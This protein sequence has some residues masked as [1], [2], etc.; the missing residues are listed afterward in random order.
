MGE[1]ARRAV[2]PVGDQFYVTHCTTTDSVLNNPGYTVRAASSDD[3]DALDAAFRYPPYELPIDMWRDLPAVEEAPRRLARTAPK[4][5]GPVWAVHS[6]Y[7]AKDTVD[8]DRSYFSH[9]LLLDSA[10]PAAVLESWGA[11]GWATC[12][13]QGET[14][15]LDRRGL[16]VGTLVGE[17]ALTAFLG[18]RPPG[19]TELSRTVCPPRLR[20]SAAGRRDL[21]AR[22]LHALL[23]LDEEKGKEEGRRRL[24]V[25]A[26]PGVV[27]LLLYGAVR[28]LPRA[29]TDDL[30]FTTYE[31]YHRNLRDYKAARVVGT[32]LGPPENGKGLD[33]DLGTTR[34]LALDTIVPARS[35][36]ELRA[37]LP[38]G[39][40]ELIGLA[41]HGHWALLPAVRDDIGRDAP[42]LPQAGAAIARAAGLARVRAGKA[43][44]DLLLELQTD[45]QAAM[46]LKALSDEVW[47]VVEAAALGPRRAEVCAAFREALAEPKHV[48]N[49]WKA[50]VTA[51]VEDDFGAWDARWAVIR[52]TAGRADA[53][54]LL[55]GLVGSER[56]EDRLLKQPTKVRNKMR[57]ACGDVDLIPPRPLLVPAGLGELGPLLAGPPNWAGYT[58]FVLMA[59]DERD[60]LAHVPAA[61]RR[62]M[63]KRAAEFLLA[64]PP[65]VL[66]VY[67]HHARESLDTDPHFLTVLFPA[68][69]AGTAGLMDTLLGAGTLRPGDWMKLYA[70]VQ[71]TQGDWG[72]FLLEKD[73][74]ANLL[75]GLKGGGADVWAGYLEAL[76]SALVAPELS[77]AEGD[78]ARAI[79]EWERAVHAHLRAAAERLTAAK[80]KLADALPEGG[81][82]R[83]FAATNLTRWADDPAAAERDGPDDVREACA[84]FEVAPA[85]LVRVAYTAGGYDQL[86]PAAEAGRF[87]PLLALFRTC[88]PVNPADADSA[89]KATREIIRLSR[90]C[91]VARRA[92]LQVCLLNACVWEGHYRALS[93]EVWK[94]PL[95]PTAEAWLRGRMNRPA[96]KPVPKGPALEAAAEAVAEDEQ[97]DGELPDAVPTVTGKSGRKRTKGAK[98]TGS[99]RRSRRRAQ[100]GSWLWLIIVV[101]V[102][103]AVVGGGAVIYSKYGNKDQGPPAAPEPKKGGPKPGQ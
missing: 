51:L 82:A 9:L 60:W 56:N 80:V 29:V 74:L 78:A 42:G 12:Y 100:G 79:H 55:N 14:K 27:A 23:L 24:Y 90:G 10:D 91:P 4:R 43:D 103:I 20:G 102:L 97:G 37:P 62:Q 3:P 28:L 22:V 26:E 54:K 61:D 69:S 94:D 53:Q 46:K 44:I 72:A 95:H 32:Y 7:L 1:S 36:P 77:G 85:D 89:R 2:G 47:P 63:R 73:R 76:T 92:A 81:A 25:H 8:R 99:G 66:T 45:P 48:E 93:N 38:A 33:A 52:A 58:A 64:A 87:A 34:G 16:P 71:L 17:D 68:Y 35:S 59:K 83:L 96:K 50:A 31:P 98:G 49:L 70:S 11:D 67:A 19:P 57:D 101:G 15:A 13:P 88:F 86:D 21:F 18:D 40:N 65:E 39:V 30:T 75:F 5:G 84:A 41:A 6:A